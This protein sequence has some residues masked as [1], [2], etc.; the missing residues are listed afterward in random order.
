VVFLVVGEGIVLA[1]VGSVL[2]VGLSFAATAVLE[3][4][5]QLNGVLHAN[6]TAAAFW[7]GLF[8]GLGMAVLGALYPGL[9]A[10]NLTPLK[11]LSHE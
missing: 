11:A 2:G 8:T 1:V 6:Y 9:R 3:H 7:R 4:L 5:P 10:A